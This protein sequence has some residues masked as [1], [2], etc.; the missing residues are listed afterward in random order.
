MKHNIES[1]WVMLLTTILN[2][3]ALDQLSSILILVTH[4]LIWSPASLKLFQKQFNSESFDSIVQS[5]Y[6]HSHVLKMID[7]D[8]THFIPCPCLVQM[9]YDMC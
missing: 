2:V 3:V 1:H 9:D 5:I 7:Y 6:M 4:F 8:L